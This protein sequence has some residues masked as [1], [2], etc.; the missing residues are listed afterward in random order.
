MFKLKTDRCM[1]GLV[2][3]KQ[4]MMSFAHSESGSYDLER[5]LEYMRRWLPEMDEERTREA[6]YRI[7][8]LDAFSV[9][10]CQDVK[11]LAAERGFT[12]TYHRGGVTPIMQWN[13][14]GAHKPFETEYLELENIDFLH[15]LEDS[16]TAFIFDD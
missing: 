4:V 9:H 2:V 3:P 8:V 12:V 6:D 14:T 13:D 11:D 5:F 15:Q 10:H 16:L 1:K 7:L